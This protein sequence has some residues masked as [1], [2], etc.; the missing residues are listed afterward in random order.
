MTSTVLPTPAP[1]NIA[2]LPPCASGV[3]RSITLMPVEKSFVVP[4]WLASAGGLRWIGRRG[5]SAASGS[6]LSPMAPVRSSRR[7]STFSPTGTWSGPPAACTAAPR[8]NPAVDCKAMA[9]TVVSSKCDCTSAM[10]GVPL[11]GVTRRASST[12]GSVAPSNVTSSTA[13]RTA[14]T[15]ASVVVIWSISFFRRLKMRSLVARIGCQA[16]YSEARTPAQSCA[17]RSGIR[18]GSRMKPGKF[19]QIRPKTSS[20]RR[21][22]TNQCSRSA[23]DETGRSIND[24]GWRGSAVPAPGPNKRGSDP[25][26]A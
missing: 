26:L 5:T 23:R 15:R 10:I 14:I 21:Q 16:C 9:R 1:P 8:R 12:R 25:E 22:L 13:P 20:I 18:P 17:S 24:L 4:L 19:Q 3:S 7:P 6:P 2:P 11:S